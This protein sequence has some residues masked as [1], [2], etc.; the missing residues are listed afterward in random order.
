[1]RWTMD[2]I[3]RKRLKI[4]GDKKPISKDVIKIPKKEPEAILHIK[5][6]LERLK[7]EFVQEYL[8][9]SGRKYRFDL[10]ITHKNIGIEYEGLVSSKSRHT[11]L[12]GYSN[13]CI[14]YNLAQR[15]G[16]VVLRYT[17]MNYKDFETDILELIKSKI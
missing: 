10:A 4:A 5:A 7:I 3:E 8:F 14:K 9:L 13:D 1:M 12:T 16:W 17:V 11:T 6:V 2:D 15:N